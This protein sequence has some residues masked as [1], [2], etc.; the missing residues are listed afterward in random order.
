MRNILLL[1][2]GNLIFTKNNLKKGRF[3][4]KRVIKTKIRHKIGLRNGIW[5]CKSDLNPNF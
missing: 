3:V 4:L 2:K 1:H 5:R